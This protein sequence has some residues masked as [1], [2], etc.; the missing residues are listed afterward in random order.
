[1]G[2]RHKSGQNHHHFI[3][4]SRGGTETVL[5]DRDKH[6]DLHHWFTNKTPEEIVDYLNRTFWGNHYRIEMRRVS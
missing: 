4:K 6:A 5:V 2:K 3:P 1:M